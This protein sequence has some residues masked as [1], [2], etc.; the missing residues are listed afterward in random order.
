MK[1]LIV[2]LICLVLFIGCLA[3]IGKY[4]YFV[5]KDGNRVAVRKQVNIN[6]FGQKG[7]L[8]KSE[9]NLIPTG[10][11]KLSDLLDNYRI[12]D[13]QGKGTYLIQRDGTEG[14][15]LDDERLLRPFAIDRTGLSDVFH[16]KTEL[17]DVRD[18]EHRFGIMVYQ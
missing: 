8:S 18:T 4:Q 5:T 14:I 15:R 17:F 1:K 11:I 6:A 9:I 16:D 7:N 2:S 10:N 12:I 3:Q 13:Y